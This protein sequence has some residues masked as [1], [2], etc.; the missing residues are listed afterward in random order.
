MKIL[1][2]STNY[3]GGAA[4]AC[5]RHHAA[6][7]N[8]GID[9][10][11]LVLDSVERPEEK[12]VISI[13]DILTKKYGAL[14]FRLLKFSNRILNKLPLKFNRSI[15]INGPE[16]VFRIDKLDVFKNSDIIHFHWV[17]KIISYKHVFSDK[18]KVF[19]WTQ[20]DMNAFTGGN[21]YTL[22]NDY[23]PYKSL[24]NKNIQRKIEYL[25]NCNLTITPTSNW[26]A[27][28]A[29]QNEVFKPFDVKVVPACLDLTLFKSIDKNQAFDQLGIKRDS[30]KKYILFVA[31]KTDDIRKGMG[32]LLSALS[33]VKNKSKFCVLVIGKKST[34]L[35]LDF[36]IIQL[37]F[38]RK[39]EELV[40]CYN[41]ADFFVIP[42]I[43]DNLPNT[44]LES[45]ACGTPVLG[46]NI[47]GI[48]DMVVNYQ[49]GILSNMND[50]KMFIENIETFIELE[51]YN[52]YKEN[53]RNM[54][55]ENFSE[56]K[57]IERILPLYQS[58]MIKN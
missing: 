58:K 17:P 37:G 9:S 25:K 54:I 13:E 16:S 5:R 57:L 21:H 27:Q 8:A 39:A 12:N 32:L 7:L 45:L 47:G 33:K 56:K 24:L 15:Y 55:T 10:T 53:C 26:L 30:S 22:D 35:Q 48:P 20:H 38:K 43:E 18:K 28:L 19:F 50:E 40:A 52:G 3:G 1:L 14:Y 41:A 29:K 11:L 2:V 31:E 46:F 36:E 51:N 44:V 6:L 49:T 4:I 42:S 23:S 34:D